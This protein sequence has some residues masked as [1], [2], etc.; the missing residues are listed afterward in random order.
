M[1][2][3]VAFVMASVPSR[4]A[5]TA[6]AR[7]RRN[8]LPIIPP[9][10]ECRCGA[11]PV[12]VPSRCRWSRRLSSRAAI[13]GLPLLAAAE[14]AGADHGE[15]AGDLLAAGPGQQSGAFHA[16]S[17]VGERHWQPFGEVLQGVGRLGAVPG[18]E[19]AALWMSSGVRVV[20][21]SRAD[22]ADGFQHVSDVGAAGQRQPEEPGEL[23]RDHPRGRGRRGG[24]VDEQCPAA[25]GFRRW[26]IVSMVLPSWARQ[27][28]FPVQGGPGQDEAAPAGVGVPGSGTAAAGLR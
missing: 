4:T 22:A 14:R 7:T 13:E 19:G 15:A 18:A 3:R 26:C 28:V 10:R 20:R 9:L 6:A 23:D 17:R 11:D 5:W 27:V 12:R 1:D 16:D 8:R 21:A 2:S 24:D 25:C